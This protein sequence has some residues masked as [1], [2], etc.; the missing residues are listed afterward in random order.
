MRISTGQVY[1]NDLTGIENTYSSYAQ[2]QT[3]LSTGMQ[4]NTPSD[5]PIALK[6]M[7][8]LQ[9]ENSNYTQYGKIM[10]Q[11][12]NTLSS[13]DTALGSVTN[14]L[15]Q[16]RTIALNAANGTNNMQSMQALGAQVG[17]ILNQV[18]SIANTN[19]GG[20][21]LFA[22][23]RT[24]TLPVVSTASGYAYRGGTT[25]TGDANMQ[26]DIGTGEPITINVTADQTL[27]P[28]IQTL[29]TLQSNISIGN[30]AA[31]S[32]SDVANIDTQMN[33]L[34]AVRADVGSTQNMITQEQQRNQLVSDGN[35]SV[36]SQLGDTDVAKASIALQTAQT[37]Y[38]AA[39]LA[40]SH[41]SQV[42][43]LDYI[44]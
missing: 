23:Q 6:Q 10:T 40:T 5:N 28:I 1:S 4:V 3:Q 43:L 31:V 16:V 8:Q 44:K 21:Y 17:D 20:R 25:A 2:A 11:A 18:V 39:L 41:N 38:Q 33:N 35:T 26:V 9:Q 7:L 15:Q 27:M 37:A 32:Q 29:T 13:T 42:S 14:L 22:G 36:I 30:Q 34:L 19:Q 24:Q 12:G